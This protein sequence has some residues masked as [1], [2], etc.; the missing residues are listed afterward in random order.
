[1]FLNLLINHFILN[2]W[3]VTS[4]KDNI[5][6][7][8]NKDANTPALP[9]LSVH[10]KLE[11]FHEIVYFRVKETRGSKV[12]QLF[13]IYKSD[14]AFSYANR[15]AFMSRGDQGEQPPS[16]AP[17]ISSLLPFHHISGPLALHTNTKV[18]TSEIIVKL[19]KWIFIQFFSNKFGST[20]ETNNP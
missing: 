5:P 8:K 9:M 13:F 3:R 10:K 18:S 12:T 6:Q 11:F 4:A 1:M 14:S 2:H 15:L 7:D 19:S 17:G 20:Q 16:V